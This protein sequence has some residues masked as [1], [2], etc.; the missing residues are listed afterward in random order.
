MLDRSHVGGGGEVAGEVRSGGPFAHR[1]Q[2]VVERA[3]LGLAFRDGG[4]DGGELVPDDLHLGV[5]QVVD[6]AA[7]VFPL[8][9]QAHVEL[10]R[11]HDSPRE[12]GPALGDDHLT[13]VGRQAVEPALAQRAVGHNQRVLDLQQILRDSLEVEVD[14]DRDAAP[15]AV[16]RLVLQR[17]QHVREIHRDGGRAHPPEA[18]LL[19]VGAV[20]AQL[21]A[22]EVGELA[23]RI[24]RHVA[25]V[26]AGDLAA[27]GDALGVEKGGHLLHDGRIRQRPVG[28]RPVLEQEGEAQDAHA[29]IDAGIEVGR[30]HEALHGARLESLDRGGLGAQLSTR[31]DLDLDPPLRFGL[32]PFL[33]HLGVVVLGVFGRRDAELQRELGRLRRNGGSQAGDAQRQRTGEGER[34]C[35]A[36]CPGIPRSRSHAV[37]PLV[38]RSRPRPP[39]EHRQPC[40]LQQIRQQQQGQRGDVGDQ[41]QCHHGQ[42]DER[43]QPRVEDRGRGLEHRLEHEDVQSEGRGEGADGQVHDHDDAEVDGI[44]ADRLANGQKQRREDEQGGAGVDEAADEEQE[45]VDHQQHDPGRRAQLL[46]ERRGA[47][48]HAADGEQP[49]EEAG[50]GHDD[51]DGGGQD[52]GAGGDVEDVAEGHLAIDEGGHHDGIDAGDAGRLARREHP[53]VDAAEDDHNRAEGPEAVAGGGEE[54]RPGEG[55][56]ALDAFPERGAIDVKGEDAAEDE[57]RDDAGR[58][59]GDHRGLGGDAV[60]DEGD[61]GRN[62]V[63]ERTLRR[64]QARGEPLRVSRLAQARIRQRA[65]GGHGGGGGARDGAEDRGEPERGQGQAGAKAADHRGHP[66]QE[67]RRD[68]AGR[69]QVPGEDEER[70][71]DERELVQAVEDDLVHDHVGQRGEEHDGGD[72]G[73]QQEEEDGHAHHEQRERH[74]HHHPA[75]RSSSRGVDQSNVFRT[76]ARARIRATIPIRAKPTS[77]AECA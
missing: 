26:A 17:R 56:P 33:D 13:Q 63:V 34:P 65:D 73:R 43:H 5:G 7:P 19:G 55:L 18:L 76:W 4:A 20:D 51:E 66:A 14:P 46:D 52:G 25:D 48:R 53:R 60:D 1:L 58:E 12:N 72:A 30:R 64:D 2:L 35:P 62:Q 24:S 59:Q 70:D 3:E 36:T 39:T 38:S 10:V 11:D 27:A 9:G 41:H 57:P 74:Q 28:V 21:L 54:F 44:D 31:V 68:A 29:G 75:H 22:L 15:R 47:P 61:R 77:T 8:L 40:R 37:T 49:A 69:H 42:D 71:R 50:D 45:R 67:P 23:N 32:D 6:L 16:D